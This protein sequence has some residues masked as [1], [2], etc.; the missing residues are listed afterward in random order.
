MT[1]TTTIL[2]P[3]RIALAAA[4]ALLGASAATAQVKALAAMEGELQA[5]R[6]V[7]DVRDL[8]TPGPA[9]S[10]AEQPTQLWFAVLHKGQLYF[11]GG[12][13]GF[14]AF[15]CPGAC[16]APAYKTAASGHET[17]VVNG[18]DASGALGAKLYVGWGRSFGEMVD[19]TQMLEVHTVEPPSSDPLSRVYS[20]IYACGKQATGPKDM[21]IKAT[22]T[23]AEA[24][25]VLGP[26]GSRW[27]GVRHSPI[28]TLSAVNAATNPTLFWY[29]EYAN[30]M[31]PPWGVTAQFTAP[32]RPDAPDSRGGLL[33][34]LRGAGDIL[35][36]EVCEKM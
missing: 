35:Y 25:V 6:L 16:N 22:V 12:A 32:A 18:W 5:S 2:R 28:A 23:A 20:G 4:L 19:N 7:V 26:R 30:G 14:A 11:H 3:S 8:P 13:A 33:L 21:S 29:F 24:T 10:P 17:I 31:S 34:T 1:M 9:A 15:Q 36:N 27:F